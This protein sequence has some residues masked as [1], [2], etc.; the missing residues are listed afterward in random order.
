MKYFMSKSRYLLII[1][2][3]M[4]LKIIYLNSKT[5]NEDSNT[6]WHRCLIN[7]KYLNTTKELVKIIKCP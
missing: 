5:L 7:K 2:S 4:F 1:L 3:K 6:N